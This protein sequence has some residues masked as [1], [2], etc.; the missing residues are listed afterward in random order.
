[1]LVQKL[2][3]GGGYDGMGPR[4]TEMRRRHHGAERHLDRV[5]RVGEEAGNARKRF[6]CFG[7]KHM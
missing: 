3:R 1:M 7:I 4:L 2:P 6:V 5:F